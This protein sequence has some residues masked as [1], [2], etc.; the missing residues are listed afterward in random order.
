MV[1]YGSTYLL[2]AAGSVLWVMKPVYCF[3][4]YLLVKK[5][6]LPSLILTVYFFLP[7]NLNGNQLLTFVFYHEKEAQENIR[8]GLEI[9]KE[10][11]ILT[12]CLHRNFISCRNF[13]S[14]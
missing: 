5:I 9:M 8:G 11:Y 13:L 12:T 10:D 4:L 7:R 6:I 2:H 3:R 1:P 14:V